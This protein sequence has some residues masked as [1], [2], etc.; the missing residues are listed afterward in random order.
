[1]GTATAR[2]NGRKGA[3]SASGAAAAALVTMG[4]YI[5]L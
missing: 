3:S 2:R 4:S 5:E 1:M